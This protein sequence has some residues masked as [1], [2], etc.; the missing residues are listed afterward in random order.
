MVNVNVATTPFYQEGNLA[1]KMLDWKQYT[2]NARPDVF[3]RGLRVRLVHL[4][5]KKTVKGVARQTA[6]QYK[7]FWDEESREVTV[8]EYFKKSQY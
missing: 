6:R 7:F 2:H 1:D 5:Y 4:G 8:E 3:V